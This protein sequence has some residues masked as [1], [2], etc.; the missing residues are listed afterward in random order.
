MLQ[1]LSSDAKRALAAKLTT[2]FPVIDSVI[3]QTQEGTV[4]TDS[5][6]TFILHKAA[7]S[8][9]SNWSAADLSTFF[10]F[11]INEK[12]VP[13][14]FH[15]YDVPDELIDRISATADSRINAKYRLRVQLKF[16]G[17][18]IN[19]NVM[20]DK[21]GFSVSRIDRNNFSAVAAMGLGIENKFWRSKDD[22]LTNG[23]GFCVFDEEGSPASVCYSASISRSV[24]EIDVLTAPRF[25][26]IGLAKK[27]V[28][29]FIKHSLEMKTVPNWD[30]F[31]DNKASFKTAVSLGFTEIKRYNFLSIF[32][33]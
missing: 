23:Y 26:N 5:K 3:E 14:Y 8:F 19:E 21:P 12:A 10:T 17:N 28:H 20:P 29:A 30:C 1:E 27:A 31:M 11:I 16:T 9:I 32:K 15:V 2:G 7:F 4:Y 25:R 6:L 18:S 24:A 22:F 33:N 13:G